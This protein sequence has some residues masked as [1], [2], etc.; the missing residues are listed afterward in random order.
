MKNRN[1]KEILEKD[2]K[3][4]TEFTNDMNLYIRYESCDPDIKEGD[5]SN[6]VYF[7]EFDFEEFLIQYKCMNKI[8]NYIQKTLEE[9]K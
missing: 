3:E 8:K 6:F 9:S 7:E 5:I 4:L 1:L 2:L